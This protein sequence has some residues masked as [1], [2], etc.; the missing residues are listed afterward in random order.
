MNYFVWCGFY[1]L[2][3]LQLIFTY[4]FSNELSLSLI[5][6]RT[7]GIT[8]DYK[9]SKIKHLYCLQRFEALLHLQV[10]EDEDIHYLKM[11]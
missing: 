6:K 11:D 8:N 3:P 9:G 7:L 2:E 10:E 5:F 1:L 4:S